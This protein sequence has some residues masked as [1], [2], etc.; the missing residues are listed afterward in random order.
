M[1]NENILIIAQNSS[2][3]PISLFV[4]VG[5]SL[6]I[7]GS[8][9]GS[10]CLSQFDKSTRLKILEKTPGYVKLSEDGK[11]K[12]NIQIDNIAKKGRHIQESSNTKGVIDIGVPLYIPK[13]NINAAL[14]VTLLSGQVQELLGSDFI[15]DKLNEA[16][17][18][19]YGNLGLS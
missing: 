9:S 5:T 17:R 4:K 19:I 11:K 1:D 10:I 12:Y 15:I 18:S 2:P 13:L 8:F 3:G 6:P 16:V 7:V 14:C